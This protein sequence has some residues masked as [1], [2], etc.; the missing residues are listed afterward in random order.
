MRPLLSLASIPRVA[1]TTKLNTF[2]IQT[3]NLSYTKAIMGVTKTTHQEGTG[4]TPVAGNTV[5]IEY[6]GFIKDASAPNQK[7]SQ[8]VPLYFSEHQ[9]CLILTHCLL[10][11]VRLLRRPRRLRDSD[12]RWS[13][14]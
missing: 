2:S 8:Y 13:C 14:H 6:T 4:A 1:R 12:W 11:Q 10:L 9:L 7:G 5:T 3:R